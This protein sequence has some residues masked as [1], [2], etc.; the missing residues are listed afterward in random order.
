DPRPP[1][2]SAFVAE[3]QV[4]KQDA[5]AQED[6]VGIERVAQAVIVDLLQPA[7]LIERV[8]LGAIDAHLARL[9]EELGQQVQPAGNA[10]GA[11]VGEP[12]E[13]VD[14][15]AVE[16]IAAVVKVIADGIAPAKSGQLEQWQIEAPAI[17][18]D[19]LG[20]V[21]ADARPELADHL[22]RAKVRRIE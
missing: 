5:R 13:Q 6:E 16:T 10:A 22:A 19:Q 21:A 1:K 3:R 17:E 20:L 7:L 4:A 14:V 9:A 18:R 11:V 12:V 15:V 8:N 2:K